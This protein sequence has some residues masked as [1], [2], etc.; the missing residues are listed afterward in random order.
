MFGQS[1]KK[2]EAKTSGTSGNTLGRKSP[3]S[4]I[5][6]DM[7]VLGSII[8]DGFIDIDGKVDGNIRCNSAIIRA[9][10]VVKGDVV[11]ESVQIY[12]HIEGLV[13][14]DTVNLY[15]SAHVIGTIMHASLTIEDGA[16]VDGKFKRTDKVFVDSGASATLALSDANEDSEDG[17]K[18][19]PEESV[20]DNIKLISG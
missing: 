18:N 11:A 19:A 2:T 13:K 7:N 10:G 4:V 9:N 12:G 3:P 8:S 1:K 17:A 16:F 14:A 20:M 15:H 5:S 6:A